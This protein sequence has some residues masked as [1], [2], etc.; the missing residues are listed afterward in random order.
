MAE[1]QTNNKRKMVI[2]FITDK[3]LLIF[4][5][6]VVLSFFL[7][8]LNYLSKE[9][10]DEI[11]IEYEFNNIPNSLNEDI[12]KAKEITLTVS[13]GGYNII[14]E[15]I[16]AKF[17]PLSIDLESTSAEQTH[18]L[19]YS[20]NNEKAF[21]IT[22][23]LK[24]LILSRFDGQLN[25]ERIKP[26]T[27][28]IDIKNIKEKK[29]PI[30]LSTVKYKL[31]A[32][33]KITKM[34][35]TPDS[36]TIIGQ[37]TI[38]DNIDEITA[39][40]IDLKQ[41]QNNKVYEIDLNIPENVNASENNVKISHELEMYTKSTMRVKIKTENFPNEYKHTII[42]EYVTISYNVPV[43]QYDNI[44]EKDFNA[45]IDY[46]KSKRNYAEIDIESINNNV[47]ILNITPEICS[48]ILEKK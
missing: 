35:M 23:D 22:K 41:I 47:T 13:G 48:F 15:N 34:I 39:K 33:Q 25:I 27:I 28:Y 42:P 37:K 1:Q 19:H 38:I 14:T 31:I 30:D 46:N 12:I 3:N 2:K 36:I 44:N 17:S 29:V 5:A 32:G 8:I 26:D 18:L 20:Q 24:P 45:K 40:P 21:I 16:K 10:S 9:L 43:S 11:V 6:F 7:W 4:L